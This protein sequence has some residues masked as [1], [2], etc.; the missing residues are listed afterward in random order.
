VN[1]EQ[2]VELTA[3]WAL[4][5]A[6]AEDRAYRVLVSSA[7]DLTAWDFEEIVGRY[8]AGSVDRLPQYTVFW[9]PDA[10][11]TPWFVGIAIHEYASFAPHDE[12][13]RYNASGREI[14]YSRLFCVPYEDLAKH[15]VTFTELV[16]AAEQQP[17]LQDET[18][19]VTLRVTQK[20]SRSPLTV[21]QAADITPD[22]AEVI[23]GLLLTTR[24]V[25]I[26]GADEVPAIERLA[27]V[28]RVLSL[29]P[30]G[31]RAT[32]SAATWAS[33]TAR[34]LKLR[35]F[36]ASARR[37]DGSGTQHVYWGQRG[38]GVDGAPDG[39]MVRQY[40]GWLHGVGARATEFLAEQTAP[41]RFST[42]DLDA[43]PGTLP[44]DLTVANIL[45][46]LA[47][48]LREGDGKAAMEE[49]KR[50]KAHRPS[51]VSPADRKHY[52]GQVLR[53]RLLGNHQELRR[54]D[55]E[56]LYRTLLQ[57]AFEDKL[58]YDDYCQITDAIGGPP[59]EP[60][61]SVLL[62]PHRLA[63]YVPQLLVSKAEPR[64]SDKELMTILDDGGMPAE[65]PLEEFRRAPA[66]IRQVHR[67]TVYDFAM[68]YLRTYAKDA[69][70]ELRRRGYL[71]E[72]LA[73]AFPSD[74]EE[75]QVRIADALRFVHGERLSRGQI[76]DLFTEPGVRPTRAF[77]AAVAQLASSPTVEP[78]IA[79]Q[80]ADARTRQ[81][82]YDRRAAH[83]GQPQPGR[84]PQPLHQFLRR[85]VGGRQ[86]DDQ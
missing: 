36:F 26:L 50:L 47:D 27:F 74:P 31:L 40:L 11:G 55:K 62:A 7:G 21:R 22:L 20:Q 82:E 34:D 45:R 65:G 35:L 29:L 44:R 70:A 53:Y 10:A 78:L 4:W 19:A 76:R 48:T 43:I 15:G 23:A 69:K 56:S 38:W 61:R 24:R 58:S 54:G 41:L 66:S 51:H 1:G 84:A 46:D 71:A 17:P 52:R 8:A 60:L 2:A 81:A 77:E 72:T 28:D 25:C 83:D 9:V 49:L 30:Y 32:L 64:F 63:S 39:E 86:A 14:T 3:Q 67:A 80:A 85:I 75:Q 12:R 42:T 5:G 79:E 18:T 68:L 6:E 57:L 16:S 33:P 13:S 59:H 37:D 73:A